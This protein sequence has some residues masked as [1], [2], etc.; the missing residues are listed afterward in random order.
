MVRLL[1]KLCCACF[2]VLLAFGVVTTAYA[3][4]PP[5]EVKQ[6]AEEG[7]PQ[8]L[9]IMPREEVEH[10]GLKSVDELEIAALGEPYQV[11]TIMPQS[12]KSYEKGT[13]LSSLITETN[14]W[15]FPIVVNSEARVILTVDFFE[16][17]WQAVDLG[18]APLAERLQSLSTQLPDLLKDKGV[19]G[20]FSMKF[21]RIFR[22]GYLDFMIVDSDKGEFVIPLLANPD[23]LGVENN[24]LYAPE[25]I[26]PKVA[27]SVQRA[28]QSEGEIGGGAVAS[29]PEKENSSRTAI[30][31]LAFGAVALVG[32][33]IGLLKA[34][35]VF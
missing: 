29:A 6:A 14:L 13:R 23:W 35:R 34:R 17:R 16:G 26:M 7:L 10:Y 28:I 19:S 5:G 8:F 18:G 24:K 33:T 3:D 11:H 25:E 21:V 32:V 31:V 2:V 15:Y 20:G 12:L 30:Y 9:S 1:I 27:E 22:S 4:T